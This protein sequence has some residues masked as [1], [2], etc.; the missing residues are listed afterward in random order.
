MRILMFLSLIIGFFSACSNTQALAPQNPQTPYPQIL[1]AKNLSTSPIPTDLQKTFEN[2]Y[3][4]L[5]NENPNPNITQVQF[6][7][8]N[9]YNEALGQHSPTASFSMVARYLF[10]LNIR[11]TYSDNTQKVFKQSYEIPTITFNPLYDYHFD[12]LIVKS[13]AQ[14]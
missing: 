13:L 6:Y 4:I 11:V 3:K 5:F 1:Y 7:F 8:T 12:S 9:Y 14:F 10:D 2:R